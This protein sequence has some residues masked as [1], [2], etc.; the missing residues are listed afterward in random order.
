MLGEDRP[1][2][3]AAGDA[4]AGRLP[5]LRLLG[6]PVVDPAAGTAVRCGR[7]TALGVVVGQGHRV[8]CVIGWSD[9]GIPMCRIRRYAVSA[10][11]T[12]P[13]GLTPLTGSHRAHG[14][15]GATMS[16]MAAR[17]WRRTHLG[18][19]ADRATF[20]TLHTGVPGQPGTA[21]RTHR[22]TAPPR[23]SSTCG[24]CSAALLSRSPTPTPCWPGTATATTTPARRTG[25]RREAVDRGAHPG[26]RPV[27]PAL[28]RDRLPGADRG[29]G[30]AGRR[31][32]GRRHPAGV[33]PEP[34]RGAGPCCRRGRAAGS[35]AS[36]TWPSSTPAGPG[37]W[38]PRCG[39]CGPRS[40][41]TSSTTRWARSPP[42]C[43]PTRTA[44]ASCCSSSPTSPATRSA[45]TATTRR[46]PRS[47]ARSSATCCSSRPASAT[48]SR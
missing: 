24:R 10:P 19:D 21:G 37:R 48:V 23:R 32:A 4:L 17:S 14:V 28:H 26:V 34:H 2:Q 15:T 11:S 42:S 9:R 45:A 39:R 18:T 47:C 8:S 13:H 40:A 36:S 35:R 6:A 20:R 16:V 41:R 33:L 31:R 3:V 29:R 43:A 44:P 1:D 7:R 46:W 30:A 25:W 12:C 22:P 27:R 38:R 5:E